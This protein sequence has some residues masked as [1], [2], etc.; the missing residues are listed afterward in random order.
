M[1]KAIEVLTSL[2]YLLRGEYYLGLLIALFATIILWSN[3]TPWQAII[4]AFLCYA[5]LFLLGFL[6]NSIYDHDLDAQ[7]KNRKSKISTAVE[8]F[9]QNNLKKVL[10]Y[11]WIITIVFSFF[12]SLNFRSWGPFL[13][14]V[15]GSITGIGYSMPPFRWKTRGFWYNFLSL[16]YSSMFLPIFSIGGMVNGA[17]SFHIALFASGYAIAHYGMEI[18]NQIKDSDVDRQLG[19]NTLPFEKLTSCCAVG[20]IL[21]AIGI[22]I[23]VVAYRVIFQPESHIYATL[24]ATLFISHL[25]QITIYL[26]FSFNEKGLLDFFKKLNYPIYQSI[27]LLGYITACLLIKTIH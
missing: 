16:S 14:C 6:V 26:H 13:I 20:F 3:Q 4:W 22:T 10:K 25:Y 7:Y 19:I 8:Y 1:D 11:A 24:I 18:A 9:G 2:Y 5:P 23:E 17:Y 21:M 27:A 15:T 12:A